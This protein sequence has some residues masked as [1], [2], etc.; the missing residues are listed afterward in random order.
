MNALRSWFHPV[1]E[2]LLGL[3][4]PNN[5]QFCLRAEAGLQ[6]G[7]VCAECWSGVR[8]VRPPFCDRCGLPFEGNLSTDFVCFNCSDMELYFSQAR[9][10]VVSKG[11]V[12]EAIHCFKYDHAVWVEPFLTKL[13]VQE[14]APILRR[15]KWDALVPVPL[16]SSRE[17]EREFNQAERLAKALSQATGI[18]LK[19]KL[20]CR[21]Q[22][23]E[24]Q[25]RLAREERARNV[26][27]AFRLNQ[28]VDLSSQRLVLIDDVLTTGA[29][30][31]ACA[32]E[33][34]AAGAQEVVV[35]TLARGV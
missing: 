10:A 35:W 5:C 31:N 13:L 1:W 4:Y 15:Q 6:E 22:E 16:H 27:G 2:G 24:T 17:R 18:P 7:Y 30:T 3:V 23:T 20:L 11:V 25:T 21:T 28:L 33:L 9:S 19:S 14:A 34:R 32:R 26:R 29:T 12:R 8:F